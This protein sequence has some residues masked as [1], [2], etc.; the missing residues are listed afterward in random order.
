MNI[1]EVKKLAKTVGIKKWIEAGRNVVEIGDRLINKNC[2]FHRLNFYDR[3]SCLNLE[4]YESEE[5]LPDDLTSYMLIGEIT[6]GNGGKVYYV[7]R[8]VVS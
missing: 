4:F 1:K 6:F 2:R 7:S 3:T 8:S 5:E